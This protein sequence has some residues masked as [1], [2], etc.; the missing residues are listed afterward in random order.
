MSVKVLRYEFVTNNESEV[1]GLYSHAYGKA[2]LAI[3]MAALVSLLPDILVSP[4]FN[5]VVF[6]KDN[7]QEYPRSLLFFPPSTPQRI[8]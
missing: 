4:L 5:I 3:R 7:I 6:C 1:I 2:S 8:Q